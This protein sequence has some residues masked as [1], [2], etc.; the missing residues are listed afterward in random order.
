MDPL[1][2]T[3]GF[4]TVVSDFWIRGQ[5]DTPPW[6]A[7][8]H[9]T[10]R[11]DCVTEPQP[12]GRQR[13]CALCRLEGGGQKRSL[14]RPAAQENSLTRAQRYASRDQSFLTSYGGRQSKLKPALKTLTRYSRKYSG[15]SRARIT[16]D[17]RM[18]IPTAASNRN[19][20]DINKSNS[21]LKLSKHLC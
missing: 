12:T 18:A 7:D 4:S 21:N 6:Q 1:A 8:V 3:S 19:N 13:A 16:L 2:L 10:P 11:T 5:R 14:T 15:F 20:G 9:P 17:R